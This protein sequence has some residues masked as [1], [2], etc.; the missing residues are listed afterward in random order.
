MSNSY[1]I[2]IGDLLLRYLFHKVAALCEM[3]PGYIEVGHSPLHILDSFCSVT[4]A[5]CGMEQAIDRHTI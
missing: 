4:C 3:W 5:C 2:H 1:S